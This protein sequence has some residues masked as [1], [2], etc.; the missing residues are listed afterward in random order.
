MDVESADNQQISAANVEQEASA[1]QATPAVTPPTQSNA[2]GTSSAPT[3]KKTR[4]TKSTK[5][6]QKLDSL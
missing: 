3:N 1:D 6:N 2:A 5:V 4:K